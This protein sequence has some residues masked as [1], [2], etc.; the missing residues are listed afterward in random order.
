[1]VKFCSLQI[2]FHL[3]VYVFLSQ[4]FSAYKR[5]ATNLEYSTF[6]GCGID[7][8]FAVNRPPAAPETG[9][10]PNSVNHRTWPFPIH[11]VRRLDEQYFIRRLCLVTKTHTKDKTIPKSSRFLVI[12]ATRLSKQCSILKETPLESYCIAFINKI[13]KIVSNDHLLFPF[14]PQ[15]HLFLSITITHQFH[16]QRPRTQKF[17]SCGSRN[18]FT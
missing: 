16:Y 18:E 15:R 14:S 7:H 6:T 9:F 12:T 4:I 2:Y 13:L 3:N 8:V 10:S 17:N 1:M 11:N 5:T